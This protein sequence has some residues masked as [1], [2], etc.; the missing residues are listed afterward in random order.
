MMQIKLGLTFGDIMG[1]NTCPDFFLTHGVLRY[2]RVS[3][4]EQDLTTHSTIQLWLLTFETFCS[5][6]NDAR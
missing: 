3:V 5:A 2:S 4:T 1:K 6:V